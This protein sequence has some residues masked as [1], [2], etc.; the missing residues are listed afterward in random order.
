[1]LEILLDAPD[2]D[3][4]LTMLPSFVLSMYDY[5]GWKWYK[6]AGLLG[7]HLSIEQDGKIV[8]VRCLGQFDRD[9]VK[10]VAEAETGL[11]HEPY[12]W[13][14][15]NI[16]SK[17]RDFIEALALEYPGVRLAIAPH[18]F[19][20][21]LLAVLL[22]KRASYYTSVLR[23]CRKLMPILKTPSD[24]FSIDLLSIGKSYQLT[25][26]KIT[27]ERSIDTI[28]ELH[29][30]INIVKPEIVRHR[31]IKDCWGVGPKV[32]DA[33]VLHS[34]MAPNFMPCDTHLITL[35]KRLGWIKTYYK[36]PSKALCIRYACDEDCAKITNL[37]I[38]PEERCIR[39]ILTKEFGKLSGW[40]QTLAYLHGSRIC[41][42][43]NPKCDRCILRKLCP[44]SP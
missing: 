31:L 16:P 41:R 10:V 27:F 5:D 13:S 44:S 30:S 20:R 8:R 28:E 19:W 11:W 35:A 23:W 38:C 25:Q 37:P 36:M 12:E 43:F 40:V 18:D 29:R 3:L 33:T 26:A 7:N 17:L 42:S 2:Y 39:R 6:Y 14:L 32:A 4:K 34:M 9:T 1:M 15:Q 24:I 21:I 22:S